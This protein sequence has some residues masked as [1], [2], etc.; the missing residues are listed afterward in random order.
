MRRRTIW[1]TNLSASTKPI[2]EAQLRTSTRQGESP[3]VRR[4]TGGNKDAHDWG[5]GRAF[6]KQLLETKGDPAIPDNQVEGWRID[7]DIWDAISEHLGERYKKE[8][9]NLKAPD[10]STV[11][12][13]FRSELEMFRN[14]NRPN[15]AQ[16]NY[17]LIGPIPP[18][19][20][21][22]APDRRL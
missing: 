16:P 7:G 20:G 17:V 1:V 18:L 22:P 4:N 19:Q 2:R 21:I 12:R 6:F 14:A 10:S 5:E 11:R 13:K 8:N 9:R 3:P 15:L